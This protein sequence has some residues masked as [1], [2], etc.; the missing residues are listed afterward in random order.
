MSTSE[1]GAK[2]E[3]FPAM[4]LDDMTCTLHRSPVGYVGLC[5]SM[6]SDRNDDEVDF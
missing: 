3:P 1:A 6:Q 4:R 2:A 5:S